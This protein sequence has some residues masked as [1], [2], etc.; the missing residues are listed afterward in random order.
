MEYVVILGGFKLAPL[1]WVLGPF[2]SPE[3]ADAF[4]KE[5][6]NVFSRKFAL[7]PPDI[8]FDG[9]KLCQFKVSYPP[10]P[11]GVP[12]SVKFCA[13]HAAMKCVSCSTY[14]VRECSTCGRP[15]CEKCRHET[16]QVGFCY[17]LDEEHGYMVDVEQRRKVSHET[18]K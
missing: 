18:N 9:K 1:H 13:K 2:P 6:G 3:A 11:C 5:Y 16:K 15:L 7:H 8:L 17:G 10:G 12:A 4:I 14:A